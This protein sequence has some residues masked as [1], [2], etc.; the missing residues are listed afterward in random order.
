[1]RHSPLAGTYEVLA[2][3]SSGLNRAS[4]APYAITSG[5]GTVTLLVDQTVNGGSWQSLGFFYLDPATV[6]ISVSNQDVDGFVIADAI[7]VI[8]K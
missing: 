3:W 5:G 8:R 4:N 7:K 1:M 6:E 2:R